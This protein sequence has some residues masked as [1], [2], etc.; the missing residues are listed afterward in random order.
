MQR[1]RGA[2][3]DDVLKRYRGGAEDQR[4]P[5]SRVQM[6]GCA[7]VQVQGRGADAGVQGC[8][9]GDVQRCKCRFIRC[10]GG[11]DAEKEMQR[12]RCR[13]AGAEVQRNRCIGE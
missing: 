10:R 6:W 8:S 3:A 1:C 13:G 4:S 5:E 9:G 11:V 12:R 7:D 2:G